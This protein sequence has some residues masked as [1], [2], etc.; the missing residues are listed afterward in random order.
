M[1]QLY[2]FLVLARISVLERFTIDVREWKSCMKKVGKNKKRV[3][4]SS[5]D[6]LRVVAI[7]AVIL[8]HTTTRTIGIAHNN[9]PTV[10]WSLLLNQFARFAVPLFFMI[11]G[12]VLELGQ[13]FQVNYIQYLYHR[14]SKILIPYIFWSAVYYY[15]VYTQHTISF[16]KALP[17]G[18]SSYQLYFIPTL[19]IFYLIFPFIHAFVRL[20]GKVPILI[21]LGL[22]Q[23]AILSHTYYV[24]PLPYYYPIS[25]ALLNFY[26]FVM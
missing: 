14:F 3:Y 24:A 5:I 6:V 18:S 1:I 9:L 20:I 8:I 10:V 16:L 11:S 13:P 19:L 15:F 21:I 17:T 12:Y 2:L 23:V 25:I 22:I 7:L 4:D 26:V